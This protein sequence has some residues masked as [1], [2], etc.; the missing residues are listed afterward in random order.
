MNFPRDQAFSLQKI[1]N[2]SKI[3]KIQVICHQNGSRIKLMHNILQ[4]GR[5]NDEI[6]PVDE[7]AETTVAR[8]MADSCASAAGQQSAHESVNE[9]GAFDEYIS[10][11]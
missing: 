3:N 5:M 6:K 9:R 8:G 7:A 10:L 11:I 1:T 2:Y 4:V